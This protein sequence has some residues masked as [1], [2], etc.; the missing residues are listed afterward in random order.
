MR[1]NAESLRKVVADFSSLG[2]DV[3]FHLHQ[4]SDYGVPQSR[5]RVFIV[6]T[7]PGSASFKPPPHPQ[8]YA[9]TP[10]TAGEALDDLKSLA[11]NPGT[12]HIWSRANKSPRPRQPPLAARPPRPHHPRRMP[13]QHTVPL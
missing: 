13:R 2:Y 8:P 3:S 9:T 4:A 11:E 12:N 6:G 7:R 1:H 10:M 5:E